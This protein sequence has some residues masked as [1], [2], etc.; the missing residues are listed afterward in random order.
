MNITDWK[1]AIIGL[2]VIL[3][4]ISPIIIMVQYRAIKTKKMLQS[5]HKIAQQQNCKISQHEFCSDFVL[6]IDEVK[7]FV[8]FH[9]HRKENSISQY[10]NLANIQTCKVVKQSRTVKMGS[11]SMSM[12]SRLELSFIPTSKNQE[13]QNFLLFDE[14]INKQLSGELQFSEK[15]SQIINGYLGNKK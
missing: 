2:I 1:T 13:E 9:K 14:E 12:I 6:G 4:C 15:W 5:L 8:F 10:V 11:D 7:K 3:V